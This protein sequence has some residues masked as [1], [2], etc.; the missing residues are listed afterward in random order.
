MDRF[1]RHIIYFV[2]L[3]AVSSCV[4]ETLDYGAFSKLY[5][6]EETTP[7][8]SEYI[9]VNK[10]NVLLQQVLHGDYCEA[11]YEDSVEYL[12]TES[13]M[14]ALGDVLAE[15]MTKMGLE[16]NPKLF[17]K[18][19]KKSQG[20]ELK[21]P[22]HFSLYEKR[23]SLYMIPDLYKPEPEYDFHI[24][25]LKSRIHFI[26]NIVFDPRVGLLYPAI[27][28]PEVI[29][30]TVKYPEIKKAEDVAV[31]P[32]I[33]GDVVKKWCEDKSLNVS[34]QEHLEMIYH[35]N[36]YFLYDNEAS[37]NW[38]VKNYM[39]AL[40]AMFVDFHMEDDPIIDSLVLVRTRSG[41]ARL[42]SLFAERNADGSIYIRD[43][44]LNYISQNERLKTPRFRNIIQQYV[45]GCFGHDIYYDR[46][47][48]FPK[49]LLDNFS[50]EERRMIVA[51]IMN[52]VFPIY[53]GCEID[54]IVKIIVENDPCFID[55][56]VKKNYYGLDELR[57]GIS[58]YRMRFR[59]ERWKR[60]CPSIDKNVGEK[61]ND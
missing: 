6:D 49:V 56:V 1:V 21:K 4:H 35:L 30:Y 25:L 51:R 43:G 32:K 36:N 10:E 3:F 42:E 27:F 22:C 50:L 41:E 5:K 54:K 28:L 8:Y 34:R 33:G 29:D 37:L 58:I 38:M 57:T 13:D 60:I 31:M 55:D 48:R 61:V 46:M 59:A 20:L 9:E 12:F 16:L 14:L 7:D 26:K 15:E 53:S 47:E 24:N 40:Q 52:V 18:K 2:L 19:V 45:A 23:T 39:S 17:V 11:V 44:L